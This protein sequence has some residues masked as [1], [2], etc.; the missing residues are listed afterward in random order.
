[1]GVIATCAA[2]AGLVALDTPWA[3]IGDLDGLVAD[4]Q[5]ARTLGF[6]GK[7]VIHPSHLERVH[8]VFSPNEAEVESAR[9]VLAAWD[10]AQAKG[11]GAVQFEGRMVDR[12]IAERARWLIQ[13]AEA[14]GAGR[15]VTEGQA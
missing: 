10:E 5:R 7:Y 13:Q 6:G 8:E 9:R 2:A 15:T 1:R 11:L 4:A 14:I 12:P 3:D